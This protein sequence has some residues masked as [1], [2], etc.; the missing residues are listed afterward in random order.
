MQLDP[1]ALPRA[2]YIVAGQLNVDKSDIYQRDFLQYLHSL[3]SK[4]RLTAYGDIGPGMEVFKFI[5][6]EKRQGFGAQIAKN[7]T[8]NK[9]KGKGRN[10]PEPYN[11][12]TE[13]ARSDRQQRLLDLAKATIP[14]E[15]VG[16]EP[17]IWNQ[18]LANA[19]MPFVGASL[20]EDLIPSACRW[21]C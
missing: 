9:K 3:S 5:S 21:H 19:L 1:E 18:D 11:L 4:F 15:H 10:R 7:Q 12:R 17:N 6:S 13:R 20:P 14:N 2:K 16:L 8:K